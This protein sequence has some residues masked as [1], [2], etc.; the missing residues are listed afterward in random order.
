[1]SHTSSTRGRGGG[2][3][4]R[5]R[6]GSRGTWP[7]GHPRSGRQR[8]RP[9]PRPQTCTRVVVTWHVAHWAAYIT[10]FVLQHTHPVNAGNFALQLQSN[11]MNTWRDSY[12]T[13]GHVTSRVPGHVSR[14]TWGPTTCRRA[15]CRGGRRGGRRG[16]STSSWGGR[17]PSPP[18]PGSWRRRT[19]R[20]C[21]APAPPRGSA[22]S[23]R[24]RSAS[25]SRHSRRNWRAAV[26]N[27][28]NTRRARY[29]YIIYLDI[30]YV[31]LVCVKS[32]S[33]F[34]QIVHS[35]LCFVCLG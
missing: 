2:R 4:R 22:S 12:V 6:G 30:C 7:C 16:G 32:L 23:S 29:I 25:C 11:A 3:A 10:A 28:V 20:P 33:T 13:T 27:I 21:S 31:M 26:V 17:W 14:V 35:A 1:M 19:P 24:A 34:R 5:R 15:W 8:T 18:C 9:G